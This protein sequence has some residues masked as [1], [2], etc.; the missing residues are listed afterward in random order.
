ETHFVID[1]KY[2]SKSQQELAKLSPQEAKNINNIVFNA[3]SKGIGFL[4][5]GYLHTRIKLDI[6]ITEELTFLHQMFDF[7][8]SETV[9]DVIK[10]ITE[11]SSL[12][13]AE[14]QYTRFK[15][16]HF[17]TRHL[18]IVPEQARKYAFVLSLSKSWHPDWGGLLQFYSKGG[19]PRDAW[20]PQFNT[21]SLFDVSHIHSVTYVTPFAAEQRI[22]LTGWFTSENKHL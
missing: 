16:G 18:D 5:E 14:P 15:P 7:I 9:L 21:L 22:S 1:D 2:Q 10:Q 11:D 20:T 8:K 17:L 19:T 4:Y 12:S 13:G 3:A 6:P